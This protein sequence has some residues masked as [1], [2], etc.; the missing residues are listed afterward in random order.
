MSSCAFA[1]L[2]AVFRLAY[3]L[4]VARLAHWF[5]LAIRLPIAWVGRTAGLAG[6]A[7]L[8]GWSGVAVSWCFQLAFACLLPFLLL[9]FLSLLLVAG[10]LL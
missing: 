8:A 6:L 9:R 1:L 5:L 3:F 2:P 10:L 4:L 7:G